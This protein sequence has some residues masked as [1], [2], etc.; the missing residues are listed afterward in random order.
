LARVPGLGA[1]PV[2]HRLDQRTRPLIQGRSPSH[3][4]LG[5]P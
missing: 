1:A 2:G 5:G 3:R 4:P